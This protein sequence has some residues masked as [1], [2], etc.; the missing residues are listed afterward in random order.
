ML[1]V[2]KRLPEELRNEVVF[3]SF[4]FEEQSL[5]GAKSFIKEYPD[6]VSNIGAFVNLECLGV[7]GWETTIVNERY[8]TVKNDITLV[9][10]LSQANPSYKF[11]NCPVGF[12]SDGYAFQR[13][14]VP[15]V[16][17]V[18]KQV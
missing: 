5:G 6:V 14:D 15:V 8:G 16:A 12:I 11:F 13:A 1:E 4:A 9:R 7:H 2:A 3:S 10:L 17:L 18:G